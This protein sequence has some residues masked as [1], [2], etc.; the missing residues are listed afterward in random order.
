RRRHAAGCSGR[1][2][3]LLCPE[4]VRCN[5]PALP[6]CAM[7]IVAEWVAEEGSVG[8][9]RLVVIG[10]DSISLSVLQEFVRRGALPT[11]ARLIEQGCVTQ[12]WPCFPMETGTNWA[13]LATGASPWVTGCNMNVH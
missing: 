9:K 3:S 5:G 12:T 4:P 1:L 11:V 7:L 2:P 8:K 6:G 13:S 10:F